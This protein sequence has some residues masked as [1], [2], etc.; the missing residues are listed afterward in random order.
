MSR[1]SGFP[2]VPAFETRSLLYCVG[3]VQCGPI[4]APVAVKVR[5]TASAYPLI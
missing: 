4:A 2:P 5:A 1:P 3:A